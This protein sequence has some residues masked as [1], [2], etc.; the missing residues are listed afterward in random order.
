MGL[1]CTLQKLK[2]EKTLIVRGVLLTVFITVAPYDP[3]DC[4]YLSI[5]S[6]ATLVG[7]LTGRCVQLQVLHITKGMH[8]S[9]K[10]PLL[11]QLACLGGHAVGI[12]DVLRH[13]HLYI[14]ISSTSLM[15][16][17]WECPV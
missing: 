2:H 11:R 15:L 4:K 8:F 14:G 3:M 7:T 12:W 10:V 16:P 1:I 6:S 17:C 9:R 13:R 5:I